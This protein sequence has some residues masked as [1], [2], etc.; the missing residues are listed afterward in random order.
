[1]CVCVCE[2]MCVRVCSHYE[3]SECGECGE[4]WAW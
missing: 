1:M 4:Q 3:C 2:S